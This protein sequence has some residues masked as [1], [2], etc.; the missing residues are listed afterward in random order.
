MTTDL[1][2]LLGESTSLD[3]K[4]SF[5]PQSKQDWCELIKDMIAMTNSGGGLIIVGVNDDGT[6]A[7]N[8]DVAPLLAVDAADVTNKVYSYTDQHLA[9]FDIVPGVR[10]GK[11]VAVINIRASD[12][13]VV[14]TAH[15]GYSV[16]GGQKSAFV[17][18]SVYFRHGAK[19]EPGT[20]DDLRQAIERKLEQVKGF[21]LDGIGKI[22]AAPAGSDVQ[23]VQ[24]AITL[25]N[26]DEA[27]P[28]RLTTDG[29]AP[30]IGIDNVTLKD[31]PGAIAI[32]L[33][34]EENAPKLS[35]MQADKLYPYRQ[36]E[37]LEKLA[38]RL[39]NKSRISS[40]DLQCVRRT[41]KIDDDPMF[42][43]QA[44]HSPR[45]YTENFVEWLLSKNAEN[46]QFFQQARDSVR[47]SKS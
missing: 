13:P 38:E 9:N 43:Y 6:H 19:S 10:D 5:D 3:F 24:R 47:Q 2:T 25:T 29:N 4:S 18:G 16:P 32:R 39:D 31:A 44:Q 41:H 26:S 36:K 28:V 8:S 20:T 46:P 33:T 15:G 42:S 23:I 14:F 37:L 11:P 35:V 1:D 7:V 40:H 30:A 12:I 45:K 22:M 21:W 17:K 27:A 34:N